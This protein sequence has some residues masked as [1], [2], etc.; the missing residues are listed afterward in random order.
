MTLATDREDAS[1]KDAQSGA[2]RTLRKCG[3][4]S[5]LTRSVADIVRL[6]GA[7]G[8][9]LPVE[10]TQLAG[11]RLGAE[12]LPLDLGALQ[13]VRLRFDR[14]LH[15]GGPKPGG[16]QLIALDLEEHP[17]RPVMRSHGLELPA[18]AF[19]GLATDGEIHLTTPERSSLAVLSLDRE[20]FLQWALELG[21]PGLEEP[22]E[23]AN[24]E[25]IDPL[26]F[27]GVRACLRRIFRLAERSPALMADPA[28]R[29]RLGEDLVPLLVEALVHRTGHGERLAR[30]PAR[31][32]LVK[33]AQAWMADH[34]HEPISLDGLCRQVAAGR[35]SLLQGFREHLGMGPMAYLKIRRLHGMRQAL[36]AA[37]PRTT[38]I[39]QLAAQW[40]FMNA[41]HFA[42]DY[43]S[44]FG[45]HPRTSLRA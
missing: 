9:L 15:A 40:G 2:I 19:F 21:G 33:A 31:I 1:P 18:T 25:A 36:L 34:P 7:I 28:I 16:R 43:R 11:G 27:E 4:R 10:L 41:G 5:P 8:S 35:R 6:E 23:G 30:P 13:V 38:T 14:P 3:S 22:L 17:G 26:R 37:D 29:R 39:S 42:R 45:E 24:W 32:E 20:T 44:L 12:I